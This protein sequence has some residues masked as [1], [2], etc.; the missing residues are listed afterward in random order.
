MVDSW[1]KL[2]DLGAEA[3]IRQNPGAIEAFA[4]SKGSRPDPSEY[5]D[6]DYITAHL[7]KF[8]DGIASR[9]VLEDD[10]LEFG[11]GKPDLGKTEFV[12]TKSEIDQI[13][14]LPIEQQAQKLGIPVEQLQNGGVVRIDFNLNGSNKVEMPSGNEFGANNKWIPGG[15]TSG[16]AT[17][18]VIKTEG[19]QIDVDY[20][21]NNI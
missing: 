14:T 16:G 12:G 7:S 4:K 17:E 21:V 2:D 11:V 3:V 9:I 8:D 13:L 1:K 15:K 19:M 5:L 20:T 10:Y 6:D 18:A